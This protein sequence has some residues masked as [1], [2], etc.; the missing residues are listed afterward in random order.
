MMAGSKMRSLALPLRWLKGYMKSLIANERGAVAFESLLVLLL[1]S[2]LFLPLV[3]FSILG[4]QFLFGWQALRN[5]GQYVQ[6][7]S[8]G[9]VV[10]SWPSWK[11]PTQLDGYPIANFKV[12]CGANLCSSGNTGTPRYYSYTT[13]VTWSPMTPGLNQL[14]G[15]PCSYPLPYSS[16]F[17]VQ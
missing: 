16:P 9:N 17:A 1:L 7:N 13:T 10:A 2:G 12:F 5:F 11:V 8:P 3:D 6:Y 4:F 15:C 14:F